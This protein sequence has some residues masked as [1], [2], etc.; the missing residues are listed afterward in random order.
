MELVQ[1]EGKSKRFIRQNATD[2]DDNE[3]ARNNDRRLSIKRQYRSEESKSESTTNTFFSRSLKE[4]RTNSQYSHESCEQFNS[5]AVL[6]V[7]EKSCSLIEVDTYLSSLG[8]STRPRLQIHLTRQKDSQEEQ[9]S[10]S[11]F[12]FVIIVLTIGL[13]VWGFK[14][15]DFF[16]H[17]KSEKINKNLIAENSTQNYETHYQ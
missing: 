17:A 8:P 2:V 6:L 11:L 16:R 7:R 5:K 13:L 9:H 10:S 12:I 1:Y 3:R 15:L 4:C 14:S